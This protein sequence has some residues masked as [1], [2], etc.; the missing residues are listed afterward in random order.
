MEKQLYKHL[1]TLVHGLLIKTWD[2]IDIANE[3]LAQS[4]Y[5]AYIPAI[6]SLLIRGTDKD[7]LADHL[8]R[9]EIVEMG[10][11]G[12]RQRAILV[13][14]KLLSLDPENLAGL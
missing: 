10:L 13:A 4:E 9:L 2:P 1:Y 12:D 8:Q 11:P 7:A 3:P 14:E 5:D 6:V